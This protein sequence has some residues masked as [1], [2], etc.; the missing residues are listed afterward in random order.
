MREDVPEAIR[1]LSD[2]VTRDPN[3]AP[4]WGVLARAYT[5]SLIGNPA[6]QRLAMDEAMTF[7]RDYRDKA[8]VAAE[9]AYRLDPNDFDAVYGYSEI[10]LLRGHRHSVR[11]ME[12]L[13]RALTLDPDNP[14]PLQNYSYTLASLGFTKRALAVREHLLQV[15]PFVPAYQDGAV[16]VLMA[17]GQFEAAEV[18]SQ[19]AAPIAKAQAYA[20]LGRFAA[21]A[22]ALAAIKVRDTPRQ[23][24]LANAVRMLRGAPAIA[25]ENDR[26]ALGVWDWIYV[27]R[28]A[29]ERL[30]A[31]YETLSAAGITTGPLSGLLFTPS[32][33][34][35]R[36]T[37][38]FKRHMRDSGALEYWRAKGWPPQCHPTTGDDFVCS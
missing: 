37:A 4:A 38:S 31:A 14:E 28:G 16:R 11:R 19:R 29:P 33:A 36:K 9:T 34:A 7:V 21:A 35:M 26:P 25:P 24:L 22:D 3:Y 8:I 15:E 30:A 20:A 32:Y 17:D 6:V 12:L 18:A 10:E 23:E 1:L 13:E 27:Y 2:A 5:L